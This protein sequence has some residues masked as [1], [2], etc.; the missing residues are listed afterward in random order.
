[1]ICAGVDLLL[2]ATTPGATGYL[3]QNGSTLPSLTT[4]NSAL[5]WVEV[6]FG[7]CSVTDEIDITLV[8]APQVD[9][10]GDQVLCPGTAYTLDPG[11][12][13]FGHLWQDGSTASQ[14]AVT[15]DGDYSVTVTNGAG[16]SGSDEVTIE[17]VEPAEIELGNDTTLCPGEELALAVLAPP[18][19]TTWST[20]ATTAGITVTEA[21]E[22]WVNVTIQGC[23]FVEYI[24]VDYTDLPAIDLGADQGLCANST[25]ELEA[26]TAA[27]A[28]LL[29]DDGS[30]TP[31]RMVGQ[32]G[33]YWVRATLS[34]CIA[35][36]TNVI[37]DVPIPVVQI[38]NDTLLCAGEQV[39]LDATSA[40]GS[41]LWNNGSTAPTIQV[42]PG[43]WNVAV[44]VQG[45]TGTDTI[46]IGNAPMPVVQWPTDT[47]LC[48][49]ALWPVDVAQP[50]AT[51]L[52]QDG[53][54][55][56]AQVLG[57]GDHEVTVTLGECAVTAQVSVERVQPVPV[58]LGPDTLIC[59]YAELSLAVDAPG[60]TVT[61]S[62]GAVAPGIMVDDAG[63]YSVTVDLSGCLSGDAITVGL[64]DLPIP[65]LGPDRI[66]CTGDSM[67]LLVVPG[68]ADVLWNDGSTLDSL[69]IHVGGTYT[70]Q[71][72]TQGCSSNDAV[73][74]TE[75]PVIRE[76]VLPDE[77]IICF[78]RMLTLDV[79]LPEATYRWNTGST[80]SWIQVIDPGVY[81]VQVEGPCIS[82]WDS[83]EVVPGD[84][85]PL[86]HLPNA[87][88]PDGDGVNDLY[89]PLV[90]GEFLEFSFMIF[91]RWGQLVFNASSPSMGWDGHYNG[92]EAPMDVYT[93]RLF[94]RAVGDDG[95]G[96]TE[97]LGSV[98]LV[99]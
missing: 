16:C 26:I 2:D 51:Y 14:F 79:A 55:A 89:L 5:H 41:Y 96:Q 99:R 56:S 24:T 81:H 86:V 4:S 36:D 69:R 44:T 77:A 68:A 71:F 58:D 94:Y 30:T 80:Q 33:E 47:V 88:T 59:P 87:F 73:T 13:G 45:C 54:T 7:A 60:A 70:V 20:G 93:W 11:F 92:Q 12:N 46:T 6:F 82:A 42:G 62:T 48:A 19:S 40:G 10:G 91:D 28:S 34:D 3:W 75:R 21:D 98:T 97:R 90:T 25:I 49:D 61:W 8:A 64:V 35:T 95:L 78:G 52:W 67:L 29:W 27:G 9:L 57:E 50:G 18:G 43:S 23:A 39:V 38:G 65:D 83:V 74:I 85:V 15:Q 53:S 63:S 31:E 17:Y 72:T 22:Y 76:T 37:T 84:C 32:G 1:N 66:L